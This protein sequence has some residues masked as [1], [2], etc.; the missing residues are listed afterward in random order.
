MQVVP[1]DTEGRMSN[2]QPI[3]TAPR[4]GTEVLCTWVHDIDGRRWW[5][6]HVHVLAYWPNWHDEGKGAWVLDGD[7]ATKFDPDGIHHEPPYNCSEP[8][9]WMPLPEPPK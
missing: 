8:T 4:D 7:F 9:H 6:G 1:L 5:S 3:A 2:W